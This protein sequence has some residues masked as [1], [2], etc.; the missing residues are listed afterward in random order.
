MPKMYK[1]IAY[2]VDWEGFGGDMW[3]DEIENTI[4]NGGTCAHAN[5]F[6]VGEAKP[7]E[8]D[9]D[10]DINSRL[11]SVDDFEKYF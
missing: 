2:V 5:C 4:G 10:L 1:I 8:W 3:C 7:F 6:T 11:A 9:D